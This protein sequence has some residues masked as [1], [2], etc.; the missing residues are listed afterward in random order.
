MISITLDDSKTY[1][2]IIGFGAAFTDATGY[3]FVNLSSDIQKQIVEAYWGEKGISYTVGRV[4]VASCDF[5]VHE[6]SYCDTDGD[7][8][9][10]TWALTPE[11]FNYKIP[12]I[13]QAQQKSGG[14]LKLFSTPWSAPGW[15]KTNGDMKGHGQLKGDVGGEYYQAFALYYYK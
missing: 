6:Y 9:M 14:N 5:S 1:Q 10:T 7:F 15:M 8:N 11:D 12:L 4:P 2:T 3:N 13:K